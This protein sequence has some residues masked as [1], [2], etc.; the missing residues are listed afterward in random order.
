MPSKLAKTLTFLEGEDGIPVE[1]LK[2]KFLPETPDVDWIKKL[3]KEGDWFIVTK[4]NQIRKRTHERKA[5]LESNI[6]I[7]FLEKSWIKINFWGMAWRLIKYWPDL[8]E[9][10]MKLRKNGSLSLTIN[11]TIKQVS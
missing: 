7:V 1:H 3:S 4:D 5:W 8:K 2:D 10:I 6:P 9:K 11:G